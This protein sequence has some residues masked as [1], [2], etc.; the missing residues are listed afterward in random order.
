[1]FTYDDT[2][3]FSEF[4]CKFLCEQEPGWFT[5]ERLKKNRNNR[6]Y[7]DYVQHKAGNTLAAPYSP[8]GNEK[9]LIST[10]LNWA[11]VNDSLTPT[12]FTIPAVIERIQKQGNPFHSFIRTENS[13]QFTNVLS[14]LK[15]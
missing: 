4:V 12:M 11:E 15:T 1:M 8:R 5:T 7:L 2:C 6:L 10:P 13:Q 14:Q 3:I 9:G